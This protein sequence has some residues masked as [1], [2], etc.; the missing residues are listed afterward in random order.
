M[1]KTLYAGRPTVQPASESLVESQLDRLAQQGARFIRQAAVKSGRR[2]AV[3]NACLSLSVSP[4]LSLVLLFFMPQSLAATL[5]LLF[6][7]I[8]AIPSLAYLST[9]LYT[10]I[11]TTPSRQQS[12]AL[13]DHQ[14]G[15]KDDL[16]IVDEFLHTPSPTEFEQAALVNC[17]TAVVQALDYKLVPF[18]ACPGTLS[19]F[20]IS[21]TAL[22]I[23]ASTSIVLFGT[24]MSPL[25]SD[26][27]GSHPTGQNTLTN[28]PVIIANN[29]RDN[30]K[31]NRETLTETAPATKQFNAQTAQLSAQT[32]T[33][34]DAALQALMQNNGAVTEGA[35]ASKTTALYTAASRDNSQAITRHSQPPAQLTTSSMNNL[36]SAN[37]RSG[38]GASD[39]AQ[40]GQQPGSE[41]KEAI[42]SPA[43]NINV[44]QS[45]EQSQSGELPPTSLSASRQAQR[46]PKQ[47]QQQDSGKNSG[48]R[49]SSG[50]QQDRNSQ[51]TSTQGDDSQKTSRG[52][53]QLMLSV[54]MQD[55]FIGTPGPGLQKSTTEQQPAEE[56]PFSAAPSQS[57]GENLQ[58]TTIHQKPII[59]FWEKQMINDFFTRQHQRSQQG[60]RT[61]EH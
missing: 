1:E 56:Q 24:F 35:G 45:A 13:F 9:Q 26:N 16:Q 6:I 27:A 49:Q 22:L 8:L 52:V 15:F 58:S 34:A 61:N 32:T 40:D 33:T 37:E 29:N 19:G 14:L 38:T 5:G 55:Q 4:V 43:S 36:L 46:K 17:N 20:Q 23:A 10:A 11:T 42:N 18:P 48:Q 28:T 41:Q 25:S 44:G 51:N 31:Q 7:G 53:N 59:Q 57:R 21:L 50:S 54:P 12:L 2:K 39:E 47:S 3:R 60:E 30:E